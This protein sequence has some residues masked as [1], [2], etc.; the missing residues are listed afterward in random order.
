[1]VLHRRAPKKK[2]FTATRIEAYACQSGKRQ[3]IYRDAKSPGP[4][5]RVTAVSSGGTCSSRA[6]TA[7]LFV[8]RSVLLERGNW[9]RL[10]LELA[11]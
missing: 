5:F 1:M 9:E 6:C 11:G 7:K 3:S 4:G 10:V 2:N 8:S